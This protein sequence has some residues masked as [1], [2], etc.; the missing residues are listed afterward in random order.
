MHKARNA[1]S[2]AAG[3]RKYIVFRR[4]GS[5]QFAP[6]L[7]GPLIILLRARPC[8]SAAPDSRRSRSGI[9]AG[10]PSL[11]AASD[12]IEADVRDVHGSANRPA[13]RPEPVES[14]MPQV[15]SQI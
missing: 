13:A 7:V 2:F 14:H 3:D 12:S 15:R 4:L 11:A 6:A 1:H 10:S 5:D 9:Q 8:L